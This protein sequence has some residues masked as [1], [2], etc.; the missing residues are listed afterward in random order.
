MQPVITLSL[1]CPLALV[2]QK[3]ECT[4]NDRTK[5]QLKHIRPL[6]H[7][8]HCTDR[9]YS[10]R[11]KVRDKATEPDGD[12]TKTANQIPQSHT[13]PSPSAWPIRIRA[14]R[15]IHTQTP[16]KQSSQR[17]QTLRCDFPAPETLEREQRSSPTSVLPL[18]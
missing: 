7:G 17:R 8:W 10:R 15:A 11:S 12:G 5:Q 13:P 16:E 1:T 2:L 14:A 18:L 6:S 3:T 9:L 4:P